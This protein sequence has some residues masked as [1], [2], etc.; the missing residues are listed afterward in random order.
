[1]KSDVPLVFLV[2]GYLLFVVG[3]WQIHHAAALIVGGACMMAA[4][5]RSRAV[6][7]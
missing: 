2:V 3:I 7:K 5:F 6:K 1:M 4:A